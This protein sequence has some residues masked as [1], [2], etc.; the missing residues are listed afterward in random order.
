MQ[1]YLNNQPHSTGSSWKRPPLITF[2]SHYSAFLVTREFD[3]FPAA[4]W[5]WRGVGEGLIDKPIVGFLQLECW[6]T[7]SRLAGAVEERYE[8]TTI[9]DLYSQ[10]ARVSNGVAC[11]GSENGARQRQS[12]AVD[13]MSERYSAIHARTEYRA[14]YLYFASAVPSRTTY[15]RAPHLAFVSFI[16]FEL[17]ALSVALALPRHTRT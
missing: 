9:R 8:S 11:H 10:A 17:T 16:C 6:G 1:G 15:R 7:S 12:E 14:F 5:T 13:L 2:M 4:A 3:G